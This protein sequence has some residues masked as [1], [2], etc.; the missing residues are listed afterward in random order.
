MS[1]PRPA[2][3]ALNYVVEGDGPPVVL[4][5]GVGADL[6]GW[7]AVAALL[8]G[9]RKVVWMDLRG[10]GKSPPI[11][12]PFALEG[13]SEDIVAIL[14]RE[15]IAR[16]DI[17]GF[18]LGGLIAQR[19]AIDHPDRVG[20]LALLATVAGRTEEERQRVASRHEIILREGI[21]AVTGGAR[22]RW[23]TEEFAAANPER[24]ETRIRQ[25]VANDVA[26]YA[27]AYRIFGSGDLADSLHEIAHET[28]VLTG[29]RDSGSSPRM[30]RLM[31]ERIRNSRLVIL[32][33]LKHSLLVEAPGVIADH[34]IAFLDGAPQ[35]STGSPS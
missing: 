28:L 22:D 32:P 19:I 8:A 1:G 21:A 31:H 20:K 14:D 12:A 34:L 27:E 35:P 5:H 15:G 30:S 10:H 11:V 29:E 16:A 4:I 24:V 17:V 13:F 2:P 3:V 18:S 23:F 25:L 26:S 7:D 33:R 9:S 6:S